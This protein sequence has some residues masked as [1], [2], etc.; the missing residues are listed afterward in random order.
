[1]PILPPSRDFAAIVICQRKIEQF[2]ARMFRELSPIFAFNPTGSKKHPRAG[3]GG[4]DIEDLLKPLRFNPKNLSRGSGPIG[5]KM[6][7]KL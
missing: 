6:N 1:M 5:G 4:R 7:A 2:M 3:A